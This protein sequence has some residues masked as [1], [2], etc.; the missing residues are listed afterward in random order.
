[1]NMKRLLL[2]SAILASL[3]V[4][5]DIRVPAC[6]RARIHATVAPWA[7]PSECLSTCLDICQ[8]S[9]ADLVNACS[10]RWGDGPPECACAC[11]NT[12]GTHECEDFPRCETVYNATQ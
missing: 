11:S 10:C 12:E 3:S 1:M 4:V 2:V 8:T 7:A 5:S 6:A 9:G